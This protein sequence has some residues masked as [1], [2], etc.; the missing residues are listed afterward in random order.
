MKRLTLLLLSLVVLGLRPCSAQGDSIVRTHEP[1]APTSLDSQP[2]C[3]PIHSTYAVEVGGGMIA[4]TYLSPLRYHGV[5]LALTGDW[6][7]ALPWHRGM[8]M[9]FQARIEGMRLQNPAGNATE[10]QG[11]VAFDWLVRRGWHVTD[12]LTL[13]AGGGVGLYAGCIYMPRN[14]N[15]PAAA[16]ARISLQ[17]T[18]SA[19]YRLR[20]GRLYLT[21]RDEAVTPIVGAMFSQDYG[22]PYYNIYLGNRSGL[23]HAAW[24]GNNFCVDN[25]LGVRL[26]FGRGDLGVGYRFRLYQQHVCN[27]DTRI[28]THAA[29]I[30]W[31]P[32]K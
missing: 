2:E 3:R 26:H 27:L 19:S 20:L 12:R 14:G 18:L 30:S 25:L 21:V 28:A 7:K 1:C 32:R 23:V 31:T 11:A 8:S 5:H 9:S 24:W 15:N 13:A 29:V 17:G 16:K 10:W 4:D 22:Q 6:T